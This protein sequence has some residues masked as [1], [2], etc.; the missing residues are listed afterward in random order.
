MENQVIDYCTQIQAERYLLNR[1]KP[2]DEMYYQMHLE[3]CNKCRMYVNSVRRLS[4]LVADQELAYT[5]VKKKLWKARKVQLWSVLSIAAC[6]AVIVGI[7]QFWNTTTKDEYGTTSQK[8]NVNQRY[9]GDMA[10]LE[11]EMIYPDKEIVSLNEEKTLEFMWNM[12]ATFRL[13]IGY[14]EQTI[15]DTTGVGD[16]FRIEPEKIINTDSLHWV[17]T[18]EEREFNGIILIDK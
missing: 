17:L 8:T 11:I 14:G 16:S 9:R 1:M 5:P 4:C 2:D 12:E 18:F 10:A 15:V 6:I 3:K 7:S 13:V